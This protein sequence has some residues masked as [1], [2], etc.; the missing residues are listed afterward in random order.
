MNELTLKDA[1][2]ATHMLTA[3]AAEQLYK[4]LG[5][6]YDQKQLKMTEGAVK[7]ARNALGE[8]LKEL[9]K[10]RIPRNKT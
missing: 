6:V 9:K 2:M 1:V 8:L 4:L 3:N 5:D 7:L 10:Q